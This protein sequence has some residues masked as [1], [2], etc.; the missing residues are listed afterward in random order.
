MTDTIF[1][2]PILTILSFF[3]GAL[4]SHIYHRLTMQDMRETLADDAS[5]YPTGWASR[6]MINLQEENERLEKEL[7]QL[8]DWLDKLAKVK[9]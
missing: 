7:E 3:V 4:A 8:R 9:F 5:E 6:V 2:N 1:L